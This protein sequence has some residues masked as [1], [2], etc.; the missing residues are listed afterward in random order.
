MKKNDGGKVIIFDTTL[1]DGEQ[2]PGATMN[3][4]EKLEV[5]VGGLLRH[6]QDEDETDRPV[7]RRVELDRVT[8]THERANRLAQPAHP[9]VWNGDALAQPR[10]AQAL[11][12]EQALQD[13]RAP[14]PGLTL[15]QCGNLLENGLL[16]GRRHIDQDM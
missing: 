12:G 5:Q 8:R 10:G 1:R 11:A 9:A 3:L 2:S 13:L 6:Q 4:A 15:E 16:V 7:V 14:H